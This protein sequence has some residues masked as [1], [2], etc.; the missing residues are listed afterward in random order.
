MIEKLKKLAAEGRF[1]EVNYAVMTD[2]LQHC[3]KDEKLLSSILNSIKQSEIVYEEDEVEFDV[4]KVHS[5]ILVSSQRSFE[6]AQEYKGM[7]TAVLDFANSHSVW[8]NPFVSWAQEESLCRCSTLY[9]CLKTEKNLDYFYNQHIRDYEDWVLDEMWNDDMIYIPEV[10]VFKTDASVPEMMDES[11]WFNV[12]I[13]VAAAPEL[14]KYDRYDT[15][16]YEILMRKR[17]RRIL[18]LASKHNVEALILGAFWCWAFANPPEIVAHLFK[19]ELRNFCFKIVDFPIYTNDFWPRNNYSIF[20]EILLWE[21]D[22]DSVFYDLKRFKEAQANSYRTALEEIRNWRKESHWMRYIFPQIEWLWHSTISKRYAISSLD[23]AKAYLADDELRDHLIEISLALLD[24]K[25]N[26]SEDIFWIVDAMKLHS[27]MTLFL[28][29]E[30]DNEVFNSVIQKFYNWELD[31]KTLSILGVLWEE[32][33]AKIDNA[34]SKDYK[35]KHKEK[36]EELSKKRDELIKKFG[37]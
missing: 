6:T 3:W 12:D 26:V 29:A 27:C 20:K 37:K 4:K 21:R 28:Q 11:E 17:I 33:H 1:H 5:Q 14:Y 18:E 22:S 13:I 25:E 36:F 30:P 9:P 23:E 32:L 31:P 19:E 34:W 24:L 2:T 16:K 10:T 7:K 35:G 15:E 8:W